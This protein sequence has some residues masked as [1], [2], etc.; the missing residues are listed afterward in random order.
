[1]KRTGGGLGTDGIPS[2]CTELA[3]EVKALIPVFGSKPSINCGLRGP[4]QCEPDIELYSA[5]I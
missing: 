1:M 4:V 5:A 2:T 3:I